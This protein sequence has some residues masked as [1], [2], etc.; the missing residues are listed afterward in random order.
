VHIDCESIDSFIY[1]F[2][3]FEDNGISIHVLFF[4]T[5]NPGVYAVL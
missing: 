4:L 5:N 3:H 2:F 1:S